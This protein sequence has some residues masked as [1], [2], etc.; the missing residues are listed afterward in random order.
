MKLV[1]YT[2]SVQLVR[3]QSCSGATITPVDYTA[4]ANFDGL[5]YWQ[6]SGSGTQTPA[7]DAITD[8]I[9]VSGGSGCAISTS[10]CD[11]SQ[12]SLGTPV[13]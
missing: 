7:V 9:T 2:L 10:S 12:A 1:L 8:F 5:T 6:N 11:I 3:S 13:C 4:S